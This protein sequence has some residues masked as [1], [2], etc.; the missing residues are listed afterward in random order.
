[1]NNGTCPKCGEDLIGDGFTMVLHCPHSEE[2]IPY[3]EGDAGPIY[4]NFT[5]EE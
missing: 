3:F 4:C 1:M 5:E 2:D